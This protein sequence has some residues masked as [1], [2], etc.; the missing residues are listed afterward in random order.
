MPNVNTTV[1][2]EV[3]G[4]GTITLG[5]HG[6]T[7]DSIYTPLV[8]TVAGGLLERRGTISAGTAV[9]LYDVGQGD[10]PATWLKFFFWCSAACQLQLI[11]EGTPSDVILDVAATDPVILSL[12]KMLASV[13]SS[14][15]I[16]DGATTTLVLNKILAGSTAGGDYHM[17]LVL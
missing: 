5:K 2:I 3:S 6:A 1:V 7:T 10:L 17:I 11:A 4:H 16:S 14:N 8:T 13:T 15:E 9:T 12:G